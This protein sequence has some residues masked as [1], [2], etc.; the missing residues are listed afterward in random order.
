ME[1]L[2][3]NHDYVFHDLNTFSKRY[4]RNWLVTDII[5]TVEAAKTLPVYQKLHF[6]DKVG[7]F[8]M[9]RLFL[10]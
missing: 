6:E 1:N 3:A 7:L 10:D 4:K 5:L 9:S 2:E 8:K